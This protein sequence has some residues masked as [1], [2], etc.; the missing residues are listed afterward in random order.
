M[1]PEPEPS[2]SYRQSSSTSR[3]TTGKNVKVFALDRKISLIA[4]FA[5]LTVVAVD[6]DQEYHLSSGFFLIAKTGD[7]HSSRVT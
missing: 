7:R 4:R 1:M 2:M 5:L 6:I 3:T